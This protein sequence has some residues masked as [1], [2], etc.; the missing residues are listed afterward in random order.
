MAVGALNTEKISAPYV[1]MSDGCM[2]ILALPAAV[3]EPVVGCQHVLGHVCIANVPGCTQ[4][5]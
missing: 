2:D 3:G 1:H 5:C 4:A